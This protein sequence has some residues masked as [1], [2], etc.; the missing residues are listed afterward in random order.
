MYIHAQAVQQRDHSTT[1]SALS[2]DLIRASLIPFGL[3]YFV[4]LMTTVASGYETVTGKATR[5]HA[6][7][8]L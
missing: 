5:K 1:R 2:K 4:V 8:Y 3:T 6:F 7:A